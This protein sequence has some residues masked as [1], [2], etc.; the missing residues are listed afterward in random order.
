MI[1]IK[2]DAQDTAESVEQIRDVIGGEIKERWGQYVLQ[3]SN[4]KAEGSIR[5]ITFDWGVSLLELD[6]TFAEEVIIEVDTSNFNP[7]SFYYCHIKF[8]Q[9]IL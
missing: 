3:V 1:K 8:R 2:V 5:F 9:D 4:D 6:I 7:I